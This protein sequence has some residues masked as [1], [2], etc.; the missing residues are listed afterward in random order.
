MV[1]GTLIMPGEPVVAIQSA[2]HVCV[3]LHTCV[4]ATSYS[5]AQ[6]LNR[7][8]TFFLPAR[9]FF[10]AGAIF[11]CVGATFISLARLS[12][13]CQRDFMKLEVYHAPVAWEFI[14]ICDNVKSNLYLF[15]VCVSL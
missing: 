3:Q 10:F 7:G 14:N 9:L 11:F 13:F 6:F 15:W 2:I 5:S 12:F 1:F 4:R 8:P